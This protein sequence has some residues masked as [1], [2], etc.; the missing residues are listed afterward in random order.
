MTATFTQADILTFAQWMT[1]D[2]S[3]WDQ[4]IANPPLFA[5]IRVCI[6]P[7]PNQLSD[8]GI[9]LYSEQAYDFQIDRPYRIAVLHLVLAADRIEI[10]NHKLNDEESFYGAARQPERLA[11]I[12]A[13]SVV[14]LPGCNILVDR[15]PTGSFVGKIEPG[16][17]CNVHRKNQDTYLVHEFELNQTNLTTL[18]R[19]YDP[20][21]DE[22]VWGTIAGPFEFVKQAS[23][24]DEVKA[25]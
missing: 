11:A 15:T 8:H 5:H 3:N 18:D 7:L 22:R 12:T 1:G 17:K 16:K 9:W 25:I 24:A 6:R 4:A 13:A 21:T 19:G 14:K 2:Y 10:E 23:F 20:E